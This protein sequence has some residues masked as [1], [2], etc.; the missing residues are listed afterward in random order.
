[1]Y[2]RRY[3]RSSRSREDGDHPNSPSQPR[4]PYSRGSRYYGVAMYA[5]ERY[6]EQ[7]DLCLLLLNGPDHQGLSLLYTKARA[8]TPLRPTNK[9]E[10]LLCSLVIRS[11]FSSFSH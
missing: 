9:L 11:I 3:V 1:M 5:T 2:V 7:Y 6:Y 4:S 10:G 8:P